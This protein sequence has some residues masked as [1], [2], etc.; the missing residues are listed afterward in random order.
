MHTHAWT[1]EA[2]T[3][4]AAPRP[5]LV[6]SDNNNNIILKNIMKL[7]FYILLTENPR[8]SKLKN[9]FSGENELGDFTNFHF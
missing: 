4:V 3:G 9:L 5:P 1:K 7:L 8:V 2:T 6:V